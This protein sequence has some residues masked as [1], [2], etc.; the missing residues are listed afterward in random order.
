MATLKV[1]SAIE[2]ATSLLEAAGVP[3]QEAATTC[4]LYTSPSPRD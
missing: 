4:L 3:E 2:T 1:G